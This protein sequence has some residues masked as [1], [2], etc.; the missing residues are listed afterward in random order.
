[1]ADFLLANLAR[2]CR[3]ELPKHFPVVLAAVPPSHS[4]HSR[5]LIVT[6]VTKDAGS[7]P[8]RTDTVA[9]A[10]RGYGAE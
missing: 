8:L 2:C 10:L 3:I 7:S 9:F 1:M 5:S 4:T 6:P